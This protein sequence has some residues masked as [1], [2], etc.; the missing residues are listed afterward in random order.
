ME[1]YLPTHGFIRGRPP[2]IPPHEFIRG[3]WE[4]EK[5][6]VGFCA[7]ATEKALL[8]ERRSRAQNIKL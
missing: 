3:K 8:L 4:E 5:G 7:E 6:A 1:E 2:Y